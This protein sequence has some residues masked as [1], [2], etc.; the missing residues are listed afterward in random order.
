MPPASHMPFQ[1]PPRPGRLV[2]AASLLV[3]GFL[4]SSLAVFEDLLA[5]MNGITAERLAHQSWSMDH[6]GRN[7]RDPYIKQ[8]LSHDGA[9]VLAVDGELTGVDGAISPSLPTFHIIF[10]PAVSLHKVNEIPEPQMAR[11]GAWLQAQHAAGAILAAHSDSVALLA[12]AGLLNQRRAA[13]NWTRAAEFRRLLPH[14]I[15]ETED[16]VTREDNI[17]CASSLA[18]GPAMCC[19][20][21]ERFAPAFVVARIRNFALGEEHASIRPA[22]PESGESGD[23]LVARASQWLARNHQAKL[24]LSTLASHLGVSERTLA[25]R[26]KAQLGVT[27][28]DYA[29]QLRFDAARR[30]LRNTSMRIEQIAV[31]VGYNDPRFFI[32]TFR[33]AFGMTPAEFRRSA[34]RSEPTQ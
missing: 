27:P 4:R 34:R 28:F 24:T 16:S 17:Y 14:F 13:V 22:A 20:L 32:S 29:R 5:L 19:E 30:L 8:R 3:E 12:K 6:D 7:L 26:F 31:R 2:H 9:A 1:A 11:I 21:I 18:A 33:Q 23:V 10:L 15:A 25:R